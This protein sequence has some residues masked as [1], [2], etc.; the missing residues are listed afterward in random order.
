MTT[1]KM[2]PFWDSVSK[3]ILKYDNDL[4]GWDLD[5]KKGYLEIESNGITYRS[6]PPDDHG[7]IVW[8]SWTPF[9]IM[10]HFSYL[11]DPEGIIKWVNNKIKE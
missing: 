11:S 6:L 5:H 3:M 10:G 7:V 1:H 2:Q 8:V 4:F 9:E